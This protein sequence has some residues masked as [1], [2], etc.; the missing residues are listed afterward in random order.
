LRW[1]LAA[2]L[3]VTAAV[4]QTP[5]QI[6]D[7]L[8]RSGYIFSGTVVERAQKASITARGAD[9]ERILVK[10]IV[11]QPELIRLKPGDEVLLIVGN[12]ARAGEEAV[13]F[14]QSA[15]IGQQIVLKEK[16]RRAD[17]PVQALREQV[18][19]AR[20]RSETAQ[21]ESRVGSAE[22]I[23]AGRVVEIKEVPEAK[24]VYTE[25]NPLWQDATIEITSLLKGETT[26]KSVLVRF[27]SSNDVAWASTPKFHVGQ[28]AIWLLR[29][30]PAQKGKAV[31]PAAEQIF[32][33]PDPSDVHPISEL[34]R[35]RLLIQP[36]TPNS[37]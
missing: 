9:V 37:R 11:A 34:N 25:H 32:V 21:I 16:A 23:V 17:I 12:A 18:Q 26:Q 7:A 30:P 27:A 29:R 5:D 31:L 14:A 24:P 36:S 20:H 1:A 3:G 28:I 22:M 6:D 4:G 10:E 2:T 19:G 8:L 15:E 13:F 33:A 35:I